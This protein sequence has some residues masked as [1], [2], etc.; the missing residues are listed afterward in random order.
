MKNLRKFNKAIG[1]Q[2]NEECKSKDKG[3]VRYEFNFVA[4]DYGTIE[5]NFRNNQEITCK[6][7]LFYLTNNYF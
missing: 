4:V 3:K 1:R 5:G 7:A 2:V 6:K